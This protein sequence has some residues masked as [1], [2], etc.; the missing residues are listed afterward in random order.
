M[1]A[2][3]VLERAHQAK[4]ILDNPM[5]AEAYEMCRKAIIDRIEKCPLSDTPQAE[6]L[7]RCLKLLRDVQANMVHVLNT[8]KEAEIQI[9]VEKRPKNPFRGLFR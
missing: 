4:A 1:N 6:D 5:Y 9:A 2:A 8:G 7:R 3:Y